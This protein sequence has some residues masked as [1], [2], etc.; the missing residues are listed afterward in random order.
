MK[1]QPNPELVDDDS[2]EWTAEDFA[3]ARPAAEVLPELFGEPAARTMLR[4][5]PKALVTKA[6][7]K[8]RLD[9]DVLMALRATGDGWQT[10]INDTLRASLQ[11]AGKLG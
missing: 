9:A 11:L 4:G 5:R 8:I 1:K 10:R 7:V 3:R 6:P 2:P